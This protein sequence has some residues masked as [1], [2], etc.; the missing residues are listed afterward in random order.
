MDVQLEVAKF[1]IVVLEKIL[2]SPLDS[3]ELK[4]VNPKG[5]QTWIFTGRTVAE[6]E[7]P[8]LWSAG[9]KSRLIEKDPNAGKDW[10]QE[11][12]ESTEDEMVRWHNSMD[13]S[14][15]RLWDLVKDREA[16]HAA[17]HGC[18]ESD[19]TEQLNNNKSS[20]K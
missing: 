2:E 10:E 4:L 6:A 20:R 12:K 9:V 14:L 17:V 13:M 11:E 15:S 1:R 5:N 7:A 18:K 8:I 16:S 3:K 19:M